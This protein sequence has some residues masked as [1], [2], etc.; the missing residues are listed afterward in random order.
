[1][2]K[3]VNMIPNNWSDEENQDSEPNLSV[4]PSSPAEIIGT[5]FT[6]DNPA[7]SSAIS[8][9]MSGD[10]APFYYSTD[11]GDTWNLEFVLPSAAGAGFP[12]EDV[13]CRYGGTSGEVYSRPN[14]GRQWFDC[15]QSSAK[16]RHQTSDYRDCQRRSTFSG[17]YH[18]RRP[19]SPLCQL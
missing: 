4:N 18:S 7:G 16:C 13:T 14:L 8:P 9:A 3:I 19:G 15:H 17:S 5:A 12:T 11:G 6:F 1:M 2:L 10:W